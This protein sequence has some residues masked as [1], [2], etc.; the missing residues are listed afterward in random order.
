M[1]LD[2]LY[3]NI[4][5]RKFYIVYCNGYVAAIMLFLAFVALLD[6]VFHRKSHPLVFKDGF[7]RLLRLYVIVGGL[8]F[9]NT[10][11]FS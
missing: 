4:V 1:G 10:M 8:F 5:V 7:Y 9:F 2:N 3:G 11:L 6:R